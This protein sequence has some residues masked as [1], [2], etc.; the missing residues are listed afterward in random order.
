MQMKRSFYII[1]FLIVICAVLFLCRAAFASEAR[2]RPV[3][4]GGTVLTDRGTL[5]RGMIMGTDMMLIGDY[6]EG[7]RTA[8]EDV[9]QIREQGLN[10]VRLSIPMPTQALGHEEYQKHLRAADMFID[11]AEELGLY[12]WISSN[13]REDTETGV[14][15]FESIREHWRVMSSRYGSRPHVYFDL[16]NE[17][18]EPP[19]GINWIYPRGVIT[20]IYAEL[21]ALIRERAPDTLLVFFSFSHSIGMEDTI[22]Q[23]KG[24]E[25]AIE[26]GI[27]WTNEVVGF[28]CYEASNKYYDEDI[29]INCELMRSEIRVFKEYGYPIMNTEVPSMCVSYGGFAEITD[30]PN[31]HLLRV[32]EEEGI[33][34]TTMLDMQAFRSPSN[35]RGVIELAGLTWEP[36]FGSWPVSGLVNPFAPR[37]AI[38]RPYEV[39]SPMISLSEYA[40][41]DEP[42]NIF[43]NYMPSLI[44]AAEN[45]V[46]YKQLNFGVLEP[47][48]LTVRVRGFYDNM[49]IIAREGGPEGPVICEIP[50]GYTGGE[51]V[52]FTGYLTRPING[53]KD[54]TFTAIN[55]DMV[56][57]WVGCYFIEWKFNLPPFYTETVHVDIW[58]KTT[59]AAHFNFRSGGVWREPST[60]TGASTETGRALQV[61]GIKD[62]DQILY[63]RA[64]FTDEGDVLLT[65]RA[66]TL[67]GGRIELYANKGFKV[68]P[69]HWWS[70][71]LGQLEINGSQGEWAEYTLDIPAE[72]I[73]NVLYGGAWSLHGRD[74]LFNFVAGE[75]V[76]PEEELFVISEF[77]FIR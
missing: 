39:S 75:G 22:S 70:F 55:T 52:Y 8:Y 65:V 56:E 67:A 30:N 15:D 27:P 42:G 59:P 14:I 44:L 46:T 35:W 26:G 66:K 77:S 38:S 47:L 37:A 33:S 64:A 36:D 71:R 5:M 23:I 29:W 4:Q 31:P 57:R 62:G 13:A 60:D 7:M 12:V 76:S 1:G 11:W 32:L 53:I 45:Y 16:I 58:N 54:V 6:N 68:W 40:D 61:G 2:G 3:V 17:L 43:V 20:E 19:E 25:A 41:M 48:S 63:D 50:I 51:N 74:L 9:A 49:S 69:D 10:C 34:W 24:L 28:H 72:V 73:Q 21:Y 18:S